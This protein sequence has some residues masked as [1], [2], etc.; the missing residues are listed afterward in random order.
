MH[1]KHTLK[2][3]IKERGILRRRRKSG[4]EHAAAS[5]E[6]PE[7][8]A[9]RDLAPRQR[10][11]AP[12]RNRMRRL[13]PGAWGRQIGG[14]PWLTT[15]QRPLDGRVGLLCQAVTRLF[16]GIQWKNQTK[17]REETTAHH[18]WAPM[19]YPEAGVV[20]SIRVLSSRARYG[21]V[22]TKG[23]SPGLYK[24]SEGKQIK[25]VIQPNSFI[26][27]MRNQSL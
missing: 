23:W 22:R 27:Q 17:R 25:Q 3:K 26:L 19:L 2:E 12:P 9:S 14:Q 7:H 16:A 5:R 13:N 10:G 1:F 20:I 15:P 11:P 8:T 21:T 4:G 6:D 18:L 24:F